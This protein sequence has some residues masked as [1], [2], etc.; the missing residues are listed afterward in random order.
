[1]KLW[2]VKFLTCVCCSGWLWAIV[3]IA[4]IIY[5]ITLLIIV[6]TIAH[7]ILSRWHNW[8]RGPRWWWMHWKWRCAGCLLC[9][10]HVRFLLSF[11][12]IFLVPNTFVTEPIANLRNLEVKERKKKT[13]KIQLTNQKINS[14]EPF[15]K[16]SNRVK[17]I[18]AF[19]IS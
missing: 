14:I 16:W 11:A 10:I 12:D 13:P 15:L 7:W 6:Q 17:C 9:S 5:V 19:Q 3:A 4:H 2:M 18:F 1:M 8:R